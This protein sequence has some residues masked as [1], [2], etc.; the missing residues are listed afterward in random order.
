MRNYGVQLMESLEDTYSKS[1]SAVRPDG[2]LTEWFRVTVGV[3]EGCGL[4]T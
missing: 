1:L 3:R 4:S 2:E